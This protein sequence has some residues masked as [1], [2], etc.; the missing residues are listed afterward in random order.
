MSKLMVSTDDSFVF[1]EAS[2]ESMFGGMIGAAKIC[3]IFINFRNS[4][5]SLDLVAR[6]KGL[7]SLRKYV[8][9]K[10]KL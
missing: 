7:C 1:L 9:L 6:M 5:I 3:S 4:S 8:A 2:L 10:I